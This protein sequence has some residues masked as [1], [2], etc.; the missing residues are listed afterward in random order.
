MIYFSNPISAIQLLYVME[1][2]LDL[3]WFVAKKAR[4]HM[5][6]VMKEK[7]SKQGKTSI[8]SNI[9]TFLSSSF[10]TRIQTIVALTSFY[11]LMPL[12][13]IRPSQSNQKSIT[14]NVPE[15][16]AKEVIQC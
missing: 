6:I 5:I 7:L 16:K 2:P 8:T 4:V 12:S 14:Q 3:K 10:N 1:N 15:G 9:T 13:Y 11:Y